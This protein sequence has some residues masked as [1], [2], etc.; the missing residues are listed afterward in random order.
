MRLRVHTGMM[1]RN[2]NIGSSDHLYLNFIQHWGFG[3]LRHLRSAAA[4]A[5]SFDVYVRIWAFMIL[6]LRR[7][8][9]LL[10]L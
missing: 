6:I 9:A 3:V 7:L 5:L 2:S 1:L 4:S 10:T 8:R